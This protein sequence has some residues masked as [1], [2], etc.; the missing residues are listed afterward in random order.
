MPLYPFKCLVCGKEEDR[1]VRFED[2]DCQVCCDR[3]MVRQMH[4]T[5]GSLWKTDCP[6]ASAGKN[7][8]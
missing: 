1:I 8:K 7:T 2:R 4:N 6:T 3:L 5:A